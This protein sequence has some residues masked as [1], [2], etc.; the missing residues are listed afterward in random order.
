MAAGHSHT[1]AAWA[2]RRRLAAVLALTVVVLAVEVVGGVI[3]GSLALLADAGHMLTDAAGIGLALF[4]VTLAQ[5][6][7]T[8]RRTFG[9]QRLEILAAA[10]NAVVLL[11]VAAF[12]LV[13]AA[14]RL[15]D[16][17]EV[18]GGLMLAVAVLGLV[19]NGVSLALLRD[20]QGASL[21]TRG[22]YLEVL[23]DALSSV[24]VVVGGVVIALTGWRAADAL[25]SG[26]VAFLIFPRTWSLLRAAVDVLLEAVPKDVDLAHVRSHI[27][28]TPGVVDVHDLHVWTIT[29]GQPVMSAHVVVADEALGD[30]CGSSAL[31]RLSRCLAHHFDVDHCTFQL[32]P[33][34]HRSHERASHS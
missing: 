21:N 27:L 17:P 19:A 1:T 9:W 30:R 34:A 3:S 2:A 5:R 31:D 22:A 4:A 23:G 12:V 20:T 7:A 18:A 10:F 28:A 26:V 32:E 24:A 29:S 33:A 16:P 15:A 8:A 11:G 25:A 13:E 6:P 14:R